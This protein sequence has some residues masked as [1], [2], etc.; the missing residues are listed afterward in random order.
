MKREST[1][2]YVVR[3]ALTLLAI[4]AVV[5]VALAGV[6]AITE[7]KIEEFNQQKLQ[8]AI[9]EVL[10]GGGSSVPF[11]DE[12]E[13]VSTVYQGESGYAV[14]VHPNGFGGAITMMVGVGNDGNTRWP[15]AS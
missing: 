7:P 8:S 13:T 10:P 14:E 1:V 5:A 6:N 3:L 9:E 12:T 11:T 4:T 15:P 2:K